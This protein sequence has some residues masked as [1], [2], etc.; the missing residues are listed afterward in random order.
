MAN[1]LAIE[2]SVDIQYFLKYNLGG[3]HQITGC[4]DL[5]SAGKTLALRQFDLVLL[6]LLLPDGHGLDFLQKIRVGNT[7]QNIPVIILS[8]NQDLEMKVKSLKMGADDY[9]TKPFAGPELIARVESVLRRGPARHSEDLMSFHSLLI[10]ISRQLAFQKNEAGF[11]D[12]GLTPIELRIL[13]ALVR[14]YGGAIPRDDLRSTVW[15]NNHLTGRNVDTHISKLRKK[16]ALSNLEILNKRGQG[17]Y[18]N[19]PTAPNNKSSPAEVSELLPGF[20]AS[21]DET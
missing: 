5:C 1:L 12:L 21:R 14:N 20:A 16:L 19:P 6:D 10:D 11:K 15:S 17:Y 2:D 7:V 9:I 8:G 3:S 4:Y 18:I 13:V